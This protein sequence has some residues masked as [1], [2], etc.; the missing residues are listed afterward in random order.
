MK[1]KYLIYGAKILSVLFAPFYFSILAFIIMFIFSYM[2]M[3]PVNYKLLI[4]AIVY[5]FTIVMPLL[6]IAIYRKLSG[7]RRHQMTRRE[8]RSVPYIITIVSYSCCLILLQGIHIPHFM[9]SVLAGALVTEVACA[10]A[11]RWIRISTH[12]AAAGAMNGA[13]LAFSFL[14]SFNPI[15]WLCLTLLLAGMVGSS[16]LILRQH[17]LREVN[18]GL[19]VGFLSGFVTII[20]V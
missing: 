9:I 18:F 2:K 5:G 13:L 4:L 16:R 11:N 6:G 15:K 14:F 19:A 8:L 20:L 3:L 12:A 1:E 17:S 7:L 10:I